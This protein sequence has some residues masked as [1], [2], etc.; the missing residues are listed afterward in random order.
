MSY[1]P[2]HQA[3]W[4]QM[5]AALAAIDFELGLP[6][7]GCNTTGRTLATIKELRDE[8]ERLRAALNRIAE[9]T[10]SDDPCQPLVKIARKALMKVAA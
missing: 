4:P 8:V 10:G 2:E 1:Y 5:I 6:D 3:L 9:R 7:D